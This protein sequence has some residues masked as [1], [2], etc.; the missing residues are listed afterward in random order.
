MS[1]EGDERPVS[2]QLGQVVPPEDPEDWSRPRTWVAALGMLAGPLVALGWFLLTGPS[3][4]PAPTP[5][6]WIVAGALVAGGVATGLTQRDAWRAAA[7]TVGAAL[8]GALATVALATSLEGGDAG[9]VAVPHAVLSALGGI[10]GAVAAAP[11]MG[12]FARRTARVPLSAAA[13]AV[14]LGTAV[15]GV[16]LLFELD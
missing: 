16:A 14:G 11:L 13:L 3:D 2:V 15:L 5:G 8:F 1:T 12:L 10:A 9:G 7:G 6:A 4:G